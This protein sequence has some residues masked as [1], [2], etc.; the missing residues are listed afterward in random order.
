MILG[1]LARLV[2]GFDSYGFLCGTDNDGDIPNV[3]GPDLRDYKKLYYLNPIELLDPRNFKSA[4]RIC[5]AEC[6]TENDV[7]DLVTGESCDNNRQYR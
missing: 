2:Y 5:V 4:K 3:Q 6:P 7:C 1:S